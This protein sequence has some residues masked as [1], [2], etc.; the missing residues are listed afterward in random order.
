MSKQ[1]EIIPAPAT[2][3]AQL[4]DIPSPKLKAMLADQLRLTA[5]HLLRLA[6]IVRVLE[7][8][9]EDLSDLK[10]GLLPYLRQIAFG[11]VLPEVVVRFAS[12]PM[13]LGRVAALPEPD[14]RRLASGE[15]VKLVVS[16]PDGQ[17]FT[18]RLLDPAKMTRDQITVVFAK[19]HVRSESE[20]VAL[21]EDRRT[22]PVQAGRVR[23]GKAR[24]DR[25][26][27]GLVVHRTFVSQADVLQA[28]GGLRSDAAPTPP[29][30][31]EDRSPLVVQL[32]SEEHRRLKVAA[33]QGDVSMAELVRNAL[34]AAGLI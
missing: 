29:D 13:L 19:D 7:E 2:L 30:A 4:K 34:R 1:T 9:G 28:L 33:A 8:R 32:A 31:D 12:S 18:H 3:A 6:W 10:L 20:Q 26:R 27:G 14:Q 23:Y 22:R 25:V 5:E 21:L 24:P 16:G 17:G 11:Q 15:A